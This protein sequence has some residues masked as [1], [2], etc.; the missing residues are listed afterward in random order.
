MR[1]SNL[2]RFNV[3]LLNRHRF[4]AAMILLAMS[5]GVAE[6]MVSRST[7]ARRISSAVLR[8]RS[9]NCSSRGMSR[10][11]KA[12]GARSSPGEFTPRLHAGRGTGEDVTPN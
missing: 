2:I 4:R 11:L 9:K 1:S 10:N 12:T 5:I 6:S 8:K 3:Q 7:A